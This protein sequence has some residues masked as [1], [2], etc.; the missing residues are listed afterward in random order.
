[1][2]I[3]PENSLYLQVTGIEAA[4]SAYRCAVVRHRHLRFPPTLSLCRITIYITT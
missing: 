4:A 3:E 1:M 2:V